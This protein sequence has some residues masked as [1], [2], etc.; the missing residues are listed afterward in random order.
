[1]A[2][3]GCGGCD[4][5]SPA[6]SPNR[7]NQKTLRGVTHSM[8]QAP[9]SGKYD[10]AHSAR[11]RDKHA[12]TPRRRLTTKAERRAAGRALAL[13]GEPRS[14]LD[15]PCGAGRFWPT[16]AADRSR[17]ILAADLSQGMLDAARDHTDPDLLSRIPRLR[18]SAFQMPFADGAV[19]CVF[20]MRLLHHL[21]DTTLRRA[22]LAEFARVAAH[23]AVVSLWVDGNWQAWRRRR[24][25]A[26]RGT[27]SNANRFV[28]ERSVIEAE[29]R[30]A[31]FE[32]AG[33]IDLLPRLSMWRVYALRKRP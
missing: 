25:E 6:L 17:S 11:Y 33:R 12:A 26:R 2:R 24:L 21:G 15:I 32:V 1:M 10:H 29:F 14:V 19:E 8:L 20:A 22:A 30:A 4:D 28:F 3:C 7:R 5:G 31:G 16:L 9:F 13:L 18:A 23:S 27:R